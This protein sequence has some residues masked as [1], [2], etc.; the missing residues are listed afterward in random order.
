MVS[1][2]LMLFIFFVQKV[3]FT[4][5]VSPSE[6]TTRRGQTGWISGEKLSDRLDI[7]MDYVVGYDIMQVCFHG[8]CR[9]L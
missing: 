2:S 9:R 7:A 3:Y 5:C 8:L 6:A 1:S 4:D